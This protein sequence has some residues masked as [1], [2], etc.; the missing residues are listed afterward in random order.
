MIQKGL[1]G[2]KAKHIP[3]VTINGGPESGMK[4][5]ALMHIG[6]PEDDAGKG[7]AERAKAAGVTKFLCVNHF[8]T[9]AASVER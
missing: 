7:A 8:I 6:Q 4:L 2:V 9:N 5:G 1:T 3:L